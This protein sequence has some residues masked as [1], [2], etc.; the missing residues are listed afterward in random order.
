MESNFN[1]FMMISRKEFVT[2]YKFNYRYFKKV[3][4]QYFIH[5]T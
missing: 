4:S 2:T 5:N 1:F 3:K